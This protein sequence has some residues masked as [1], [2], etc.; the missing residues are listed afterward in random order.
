VQKGS[1]KLVL[2]QP[3]QNNEDAP[4][5]AAIARGTGWFEELTCGKASSISSIASRESVTDSYVSRLLNL[6]ILPPH[7]V[8]QVIDGNPSAN[9]IARRNMSGQKI[10]SLWRR[11]TAGL[12]ARL[13]R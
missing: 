11:Q 5:I 7:L 6:A 3:S 9:E 4:L 1:V 13:N 8:E 12:S 10:S 2:T